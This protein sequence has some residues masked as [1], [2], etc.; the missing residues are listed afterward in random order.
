MP[1]ISV[2]VLPDA[3]TASAQ[4]R[5]LSEQGAVEAT[6]VGDELAGHGFAFHVDRASRPDGAQQP[7]GP[8]GR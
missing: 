4:R 2:S 1:K 3:A 7:G 5:R 8:L 6:H